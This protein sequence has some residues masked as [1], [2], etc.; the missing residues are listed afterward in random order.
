MTKKNTLD[1]FVLN[2]E[3]TKQIYEKNSFTKISDIVYDILEDGILSSAIAP[4]T[5]LNASKIAEQLSISN[6]P[7]SKAI[8]RL[9]DN[10]LVTEAYGGNG[11]YRNFS[12][13]D[14]SNN[15]IND[16][17]IARSS[18]EST[19]ASICA[20][21]SAL[22]DIEEIRR[23]A[24]AFQQVWA[25][26]VNGS[27]SASVLERAQV[28]EEFHSL[29]VHSTGNKYLIDMFE[30]LQGTLRYLSIRTS[31][32]AETKRS[33]DDLLMMGTQHLAVYNAIK[34]G[35]PD[36]ARSAMAEHLG[37]CRYHCLLNRAGC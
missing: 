15:S 36:L 30:T 6:T 33:G 17:F 5:K 13:F 37:F 28:D 18:I 35:I 34:M 22:I 29:I 25:D 3:K 31:E 21:R 12:V 20:Q 26:Y 9:K 16:L 10:G 24:E 27:P 32:F 14:I 7:V 2:S 23:L 1:G 19:A 11:K 4:G 8:Q